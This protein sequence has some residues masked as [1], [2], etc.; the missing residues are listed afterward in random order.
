MSARA[1][2][3]FSVGASTAINWHRRWRET[4]MLTAGHQ[5]NQRH[6]KLD[7]QKEFMFYQLAQRKAIALHKI[8][9]ALA[10]ELP[11]T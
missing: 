7:T 3:R 5:G 10:A 4:V 11:A 9:G 1:A 2:A 8:A 6:P